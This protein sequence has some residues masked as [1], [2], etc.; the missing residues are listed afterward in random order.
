MSTPSQDREASPLYIKTL[1]NYRD[2]KEEED[3]LNLNTN[4]NL[5]HDD[6][7]HYETLQKLITS[8]PSSSSSG[9]YEVEAAEIESCLEQFVGT[10]GSVLWRRVVVRSGPS[11]PQQII[12]ASYMLPQDISSAS[13][14]NT[15]T[16]GTSSS[17]GNTHPSV[18]CWTAFP[19][20]PDH[21][22]ASL[23]TP[24]P[25]LPLAN[26]CR[27]PAVCRPHNVH[28]SLVRPAM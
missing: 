27:L 24:C 15:T 2:H 17:D 10:D 12:H 26:G 6:C 18:L 9:G 20:R 8:S 19:D 14:S 23:V 25:S 21:P 13:S 3:D 11:C 16:T 7:G 4:L 1:R 5:N 22:P 28:L